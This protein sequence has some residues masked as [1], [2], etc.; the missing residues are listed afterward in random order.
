MRKEVEM[1]SNYNYRAAS[2]REAMAAARRA[3]QAPQTIAATM[4]RPTLITSLLSLIISPLS[5]I[6]LIIVL[7]LVLI[8]LGL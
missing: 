2:C 1:Y 5:I 8:L 7:S 6:N 3:E 4:P